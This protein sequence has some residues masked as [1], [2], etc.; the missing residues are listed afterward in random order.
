MRIISR[1][2]WPPIKLKLKAQLNRRLAIG[3][4]DGLG[5]VL[6]E[7]V[8]VVDGEGEKGFFVLV[9]G[10]LGDRFGVEVLGVDKELVDSGD[11]CG[12]MGQAFALGDF[13]VLDGGM[14]VDAEGEVDGSVL[15]APAFE[16]D[17]LV[18][19]RTGFEIAEA[20][21]VPRELDVGSGEE[22]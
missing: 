3:E 19:T 6:G 20:C 2:L 21:A 15:L 12:V 16:H 13:I 7:L 10:G 22:A 4:D 18:F 5:W 14:V 17:V 8:E 9:P 1:R 11:H